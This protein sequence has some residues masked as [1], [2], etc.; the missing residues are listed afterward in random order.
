MPRLTIEEILKVLESG[1]DVRFQGNTPSLYTQFIDHHLPLHY[2]T[3]E[4]IGPDGAQVI[5]EALKINQ[6]ITNL[7][8]E[9]MI[10]NYSFLLNSL[11]SLTLTCNISQLT[12]LALMVLN[13]LQRHSRSIKLSSSYDYMV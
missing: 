5:A 7:N 4:G 1:A 2:I 13:L 3:D 8:L 12:T 9:G 10:P 6:T 11:L